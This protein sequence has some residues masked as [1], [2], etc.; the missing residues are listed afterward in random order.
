[1]RHDLDRLRQRAPDDWKE[2]FDKRYLRTQWPYGSGVWGKREWV[3][4]DVTDGNVVS[5]FGGGVGAQAGACLTITVGTSFQFRALGES[6]LSAFTVTMPPWPEG[7]EDGWL[8]AGGVWRCRSA[9]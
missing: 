7:S 6:P 5:T 4:P 9:R 3:C 8:K 1:M 2:T